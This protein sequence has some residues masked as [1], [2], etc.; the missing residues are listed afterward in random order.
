MF[1][2]QTLHP[3]QPNVAGF[4]SLARDSIMFIEHSPV[5]EIFTIHNDL[6]QN[7]GAC[8]SAT[9]STLL[10]I[11]STATLTIPGFDTDWRV[12]YT[13]ALRGPSSGNSAK[14]QYCWQEDAD[15]SQSQFRGGRR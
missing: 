8:R 10:V 12:S 7:I 13:S 11:N 1:Y 9:T 6:P 3:K 14:G 2:N 15:R 4:L 5:L